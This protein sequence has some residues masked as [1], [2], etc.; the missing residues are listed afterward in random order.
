MHEEQDSAQAHEDTACWRR[1]TAA[2]TLS[3]AHTL[4]CLQD[5]QQQQHASDPGNKSQ[6]I[7]HVHCNNADG[8]LLLLLCYASAQAPLGMLVISCLTT[9]AAS[10]RS[11]RSY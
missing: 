2:S 10:L 8:L 7:T 11:I 4:L 3:P 6:P 5:L 9:T 1:R